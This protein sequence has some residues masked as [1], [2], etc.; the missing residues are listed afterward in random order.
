MKPTVIPSGDG[1]KPQ[2]EPT[3]MRPTAIPAAPALVPQAPQPTAMRPT[4]IPSQPVPPAAAPVA[5]P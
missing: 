2:S 3:V 5:P 4:A 1:D